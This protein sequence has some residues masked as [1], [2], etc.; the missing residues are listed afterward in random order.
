MDMQELFDNVE[1]VV[2][3]HVGHGLAARYG[4]LPTLDFEDGLAIDSLDVEAI[5]GER[6]DLLREHQGFWAL[7]DPGFEDADW[8]GEG[9]EL[10][11]GVGVGVVVVV[12]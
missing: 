8:A 6:H 12:S 7:G 11:H 1:Q 4:H 2:L 9:R 3:L 10:S 5:A